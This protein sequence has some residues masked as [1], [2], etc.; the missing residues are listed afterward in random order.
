MSGLAEEAGSAYEGISE[1]VEAVDRAGITKK[2]GTAA[3]D[4]QPQGIGSRREKR[5]REQSCPDDTSG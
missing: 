5:G 4:Q 1:V 2:S 3:S